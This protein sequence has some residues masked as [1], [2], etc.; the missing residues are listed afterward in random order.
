MELWKNRVVS[1]KNK[2]PLKKEVLI[3]S[4][5]NTPYLFIFV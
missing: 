1:G 4:I 2:P 5:L 3:V